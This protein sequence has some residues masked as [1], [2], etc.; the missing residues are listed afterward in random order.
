MTDTEIIEAL[1]CCKNSIPMCDDCPGG[2]GNMC[3][4]FLKGYA[5][6]LIRRQKAEIERLKAKSAKW[7]EHKDEKYTCTFGKSE[8]QRLLH[9]VNQLSEEIKRQ[10][11]EIERLR[12]AYSI[13]EETT[14]L[15][16]AKADAIREFA[17]KLK[18]SAFVCDVTFGYG[19]EHCEEAVSVIEIDNL[20]KEMTEETK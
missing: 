14:G 7:T 15:K 11:A 1:E 16:Q 2:Y 10:Q 5:L 20:V 9:L 8:E 18:E 17:E 4:D 6:D 12:E 13:Y 3:F 19:R